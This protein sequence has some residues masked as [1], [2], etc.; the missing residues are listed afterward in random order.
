MNFLI[1]LAAEW[2]YDTVFE[3]I[4]VLILEVFGVLL[5]EGIVFSIIEDLVKKIFKKD[6]KQQTEVSNDDFIFDVSDYEDYNIFI[7]LKDQES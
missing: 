5:L 2:G 7:P 6:S 3:T 4:I 1:F